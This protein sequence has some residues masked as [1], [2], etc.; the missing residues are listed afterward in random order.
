MCVGDGDFPCDPQYNLPNIFSPNGD[1]FN[2]IFHP[3]DHTTG[4]MQQ[5]TCKPYRFVKDVHITFYNRWGG[6]V[7]E[8]NDIDINWDGRNNDGGE[9][10]SGTYFYIAQ[11]DFIKLTGLERRVLQGFVKLIR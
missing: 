7:F 11:V 2:D 10:S 1:G 5:L 9:L 4:S 6:K 3:C 8:T